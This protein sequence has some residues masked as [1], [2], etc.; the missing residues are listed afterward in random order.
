[1]LPGITLNTSPTDH[2]PIK[3]M[4]FQRWNGETWERFGKLIQATA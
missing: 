4:Q 1:V 3:A 2:R